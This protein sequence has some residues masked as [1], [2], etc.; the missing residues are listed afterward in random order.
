MLIYSLL[1]ILINLFFFK[2]ILN[3]FKIFKFKHFSPEKKQQQVFMYHAATDF[4]DIIL[5][6][7]ESGSNIYHSFC[8]AAQCS[9]N[10][11]IKINA[12][13]TLSRY[14]MGCSL[15][16][17]L[18]Y[19]LGQ[20]NNQIY[21]EIVENIILSLQLGTPLKANLS[22]LS[23]NMRIRANL[24]LEE[25]IAQAPVKMIFPLVFFIFPVIFILLG[26]GSIQDLI[27]S[28]RF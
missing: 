12:N 23:A 17:S 27:S 10:E 5:L 20:K 1:S 25:V 21:D 22:E 3:H 7:L 8:H 6:H 16:E 14:S 24:K 4:I 19:S 15:I 2:Y 11:K 9:L 26:S 28:L 18:Q 13:E